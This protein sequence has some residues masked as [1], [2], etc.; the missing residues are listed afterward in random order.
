[1][2]M[3][4]RHNALRRYHL[5]GWLWPLRFGF[6]TIPFILFVC[7][8]IF[9]GGILSLGST[10][11][12]NDMA[13]FVRAGWWTACVPLSV[14]TLITT[15]LSVYRYVLNRQQEKVGRIK[16][17]DM[18]LKTVIRFAFI[19]SGRAKFTTT[20]GMLQLLTYNAEHLAR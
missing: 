9:L 6:L 16:W 8:A 11:P 20:T 4:N 5:L 12:S 3:L 1:M 13:S 18:F 7:L 10:H 2:E 15:S 17:K 14:A 19:E